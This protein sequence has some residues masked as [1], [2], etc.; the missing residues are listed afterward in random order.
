V[1][2]VAP[3]IP[4][5]QAGQT[6]QDRIAVLENTVANT[7]AEAAANRVEARTAKEQ[8]DAANAEIT[9][10][11]TEADNRERTAREAGNTELQATRR[12][13]ID[14]ELKA[15]AIQAGLTDLDLLPLIDK[16]AVSYDPATGTFTGISEA[17]AAGKTKKPD[18]FKPAAA[19][20]AAPVRASTGSPLPP[21]APGAAPPTTSVRDIPKTPEGK[22][23]YEQQKKDALRSLGN[24]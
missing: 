6:D 19:P 9:R 24:Q 14:A 15:A 12:Q 17:I 22:R 7:R 16:K 2:P 4:P 11:K 18:W 8:V 13:L 3:P 23:A 20:A 10:L 1:P 21:P 5:R